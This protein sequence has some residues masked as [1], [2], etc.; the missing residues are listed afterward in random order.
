[1][2]DDDNAQA[3]GVVYFSELK[4]DQENGSI[5]F[6]I[7]NGTDETITLGGVLLIEKKTIDGL[8]V[9]L[10]PLDWNHEMVIN[11]PIM[12]IYTIEPGEIMEGDLSISAIYGELGDGDYRVTMQISSETVQETISGSFTVAPKK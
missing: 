12:R 1:M 9:D 6:V 2:Q 5:D 7:V 3:G 4:Y 10:Q 8:W 11:G